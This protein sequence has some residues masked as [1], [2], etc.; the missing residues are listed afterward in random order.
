MNRNVIITAVAV[1]LAALLPA[2]HGNGGHSVDGR[3]EVEIHLEAVPPSLQGFTELSLTITSARVIPGVKGMKKGAD[4]PIEVLKSPL[5]IDLMDLPPGATLE[6]TSARVPAGFY[7][8]VEVEISPGVARL[9]DGSLAAEYKIKPQKL[10]VPL[11]LDV[12][13]GETAAVT[14]RLEASA[15]VKVDSKG[16]TKIELKLKATQI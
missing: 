11:V 10:K 1:C 7:K 2:C 16:R 4:S 6:V 5:T 9:T 15:S 8:R 13:A 12:I 3:G 14:I